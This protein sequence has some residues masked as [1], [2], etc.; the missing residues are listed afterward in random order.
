MADSLN[1]LLKDIDACLTCGNLQPALLDSD[2]APLLR[3]C[4]AY[5]PQNLLLNYYEK[6]HDLNHCRHH[7]VHGAQTWQ[8]FRQPF[9]MVRAPC[10]GPKADACPLSLPTP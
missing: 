3:A 10:R 5:Q 4:L 7:Q 2:V 9:Q 6:H 8:H 1:T